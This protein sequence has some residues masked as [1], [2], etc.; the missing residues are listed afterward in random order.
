MSDFFFF[1]YFEIQLFRGQLSDLATLPTGFLITNHKIG[2]LRAS[3]SAKHSGIILNILRRDPA[4][5]DHVHLDLKTRRRSLTH[6][7]GLPHYK[8]PNKV[9]FPFPLNLLIVHYTEYLS[10]ISYNIKM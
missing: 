9:T 8:P 3:G 5:T 1:S 6:A 10:I 2:S 4:L 7:H